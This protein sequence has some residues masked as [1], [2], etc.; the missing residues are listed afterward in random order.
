MRTRH[1]ILQ[2]AITA[3]A[4]RG[5][6][7][8]GVRDVATAA[9]VNAALVGRYFGSKEGLFEAALSQALDLSSLLQTERRDFGAHVV[10]IFFETQEAPS[11]LAM[12]I[13]S[14]ADPL[15]RDICVRLLQDQVV[16]PLGA[17][18]GPPD[19]EARAAR[20]NI[21]W[22]GFLT[23]WKLLPLYPLQGQAMAGVRQWLETA[24][25]AIV[26]GD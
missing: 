9:G 6:A 25:Q 17:W 7:E 5:Y 1:A 11:P 21:L 2:A 8:T 13:L 4:A 23:S 20:L 24:T 3:F 10:R 12:M 14:A 16:S 18:I 26:D 22:N 19:G 15:A